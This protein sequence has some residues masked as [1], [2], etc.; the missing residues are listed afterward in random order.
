MFYI[1]VCLTVK[2]EEDI[3]TVRELMKTIV[4]MCKEEKEC[5][6]IEVYHSQN[7]PNQFIL[8]EHWDR[9]ESWEGHR[10]MPVFTD[11]YLAKVLPLV[12]REPHISDLVAQH[13]AS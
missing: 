7:D 9:K 13:N 4:S 11:V 6:R 12:D 8:C 1:N 5:L 2:N 10:N 3:P